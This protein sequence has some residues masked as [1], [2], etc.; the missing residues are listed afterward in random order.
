MFG[1]IQ[2]DPDELKGKDWKTYRAFYCG[3]CMDLKERSGQRARLTLTYD[4]TFLAL[5]LTSLYEGN[6]ERQKRL[7]ILHPAEKGVCVRNPYTAYA[8]DMSLLL[9]YHNLM[10]DWLDEK[11]ALSLAFARSVRQ[12]YI[13]AAGKYPEKTKAV[14]RYLKALHELEETSSGGI[15]AAANLT[16]DLFAEIFRYKEDVWTEDLMRIG[17]S[18][19]RFIYLMDAWEDV[20]EDRKRGGYNPFLSMADQPDFARNAESILTMAAAGMARGFERLPVVENVDI[21]RNILYSGIWVRYRN[22]KEK[23]KHE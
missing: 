13:R 2:I 15:D 5:L 8:A 16:G 3:V 12:A 20:E 10:D 6:T 18:L 21:L 23:R 1:Y 9:V 4:M 14:R 19:G 7:C 17:A 22:R 11:K